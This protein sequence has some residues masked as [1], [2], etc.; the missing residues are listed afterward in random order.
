MTRAKKSEFPGT[1]STKV[2]KLTLERYGSQIETYEKE[3]V[4]LRLENKN[5]RARILEL[6]EG[7]AS[8]EQSQKLQRQQMHDERL[9]IC[10]TLELILKIENELVQEK[11]KVLQ[12]AVSENDVDG[13]LTKLALVKLAN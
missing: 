3:R 12:K 9:K 2:S 7:V 8:L 4:G 11:R 13:L 6:E 5:L 10:E 1:L